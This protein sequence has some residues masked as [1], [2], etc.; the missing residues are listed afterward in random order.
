M[1]GDKAGIRAKSE[2]PF[3]ES[4]GTAEESESAGASVFGCS[5]G[6]WNWAGTSGIGGMD[7]VGG[8]VGTAGIGGIDGTD[9]ASASGFC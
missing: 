4:F 9:G 7:G 2:V 3:A 1:C 8:M 5:C 6:C